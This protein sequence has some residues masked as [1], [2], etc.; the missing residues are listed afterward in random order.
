M[1]SEDLCA[2]ALAKAGSINALSKATGIP[3]QTARMWYRRGA[4]PTWTNA[5]KLL[6]YLGIYLDTE[7]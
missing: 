4:Q 7:R 3:K 2:R 5:Y 1:T 6:Q